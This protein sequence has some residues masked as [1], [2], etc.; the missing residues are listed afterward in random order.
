MA[1]GRRHETASPHLPRPHLGHKILPANYAYK[2]S[3]FIRLRSEC[4]LLARFQPQTASLYFIPP[5]QSAPQPIPPLRHTHTHTHRHTLHLLAA[6]LSL[7]CSISV[8]SS[9]SVCIADERVAI[10]LEP[11]GRRVPG[12]LGQLVSIKSTGIQRIAMTTIL[13]A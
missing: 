11:E 4:P 5:S 12:L 13:P 10:L 3:V 2:P 7:F 8:S 1:E 6:L 9:S